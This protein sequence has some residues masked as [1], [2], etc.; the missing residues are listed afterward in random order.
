MAVG[1]L[2]D[3][4]SGCQVWQSLRYR[5]LHQAARYGGRYVTGH[6]IRLPGMAVGTLHDRTLGCQVWRSV[7]YMTGHQAAGMEQDI[8]QRGPV[9]NK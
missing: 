5:T 1:T 4:T 3:I 6:Y 9:V 2:Q 8:T 7:R